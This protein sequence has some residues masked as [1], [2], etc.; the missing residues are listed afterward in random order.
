VLFAICE[1]STA[2]GTIGS[3][4]AEVVT[5]VFLSNSDALIGPDATS[6]K[7]FLRSPNL[8]GPDENKNVLLVDIA[9]RQLR[10]P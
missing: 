5:V 6:L 2:S 8:I 9:I 10:I 1:F 3:V 4:S 7:E